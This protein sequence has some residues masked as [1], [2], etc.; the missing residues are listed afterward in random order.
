MKELTIKTLQHCRITALLPCSIAPLQHSYIK[1]KI[2]FYLLKQ[3][4]E[5]K[6]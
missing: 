1:W 3:T 6:I 2:A 5:Q 4:E